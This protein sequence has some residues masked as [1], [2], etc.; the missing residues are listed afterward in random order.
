VRGDFTYSI[1][2]TGVRWPEIVHLSMSEIVE[3]RGGSGRM[4]AMKYA[5]WSIDVPPVYTS[6]G[7]AIDAAILFPHPLA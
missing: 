2:E 1:L 3:L 7:P 4:D 6:G 5:H